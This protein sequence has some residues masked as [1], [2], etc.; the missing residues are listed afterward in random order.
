MKTEAYQKTP[1]YEYDYWWYVGRR[2]IVLAH[3]RK[4]FPSLI[5][6]FI[7]DIGCGTGLMM[8]HY[9]PFGKTFGMEKC[10]QGETAGQGTVG[11]RIVLGEL[12]HLPFLEQIFDLVSLLDV[13]EHVDDDRDALLELRRI[14]KPDGRALITVPAF[15]FLWSGEDYVSEHRRRYTANSLK[16]LCKSADL[17]IEKMSYFNFLLFIPVVLALLTKRFFKP[18]SMY[19]SN[20][21]PIPLW[22]NRMLAGIFSFESWVLQ[23]IS[24]PVGTSLLAVVAPK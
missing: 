5:E 9:A 16:I 17:R 8:K 19:Q 6:R 3:V 21:Q 1:L 18:K 7:L 13:L 22:L 11:S 12:P 20:L 10:F 24:M 23:F 2:A 15:N 14:M 4:L